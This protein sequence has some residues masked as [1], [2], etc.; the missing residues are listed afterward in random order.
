MPLERST[1]RD[2]QLLASLMDP[3]VGNARVTGDVCNR[4]SAGLGE[5]HC[6]VLTLLHRGLLDFL[7]DPCPPV[8][9]TWDIR[10]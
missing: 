6:L 8:L 5:P 4:L 7:H 10:S 9:A 2:S 1:I 3:R